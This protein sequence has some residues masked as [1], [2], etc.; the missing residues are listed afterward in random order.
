MSSYMKRGRCA[1]WMVIC[2]VLK[3]MI[4][5]RSIRMSKAIMTVEPVGHCLAIA[6]ASR[7]L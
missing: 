4:R 5:T 2:H 1:D 7:N 3:M 6:R